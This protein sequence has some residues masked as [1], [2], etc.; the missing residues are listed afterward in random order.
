[1]RQRF[2]IKPGDEVVFEQGKDSIE[3]RPAKATLKSVYGSIK[4]LK[5]K[6]SY[7]KMREIAFEDKLNAVR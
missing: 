7:K 5:K 4:L 6:I 3:I 1:M 2:G